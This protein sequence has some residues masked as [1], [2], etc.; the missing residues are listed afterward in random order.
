[1]S[2]S[3]SEPAANLETCLAVQAIAVRFPE[4]LEPKSQRVFCIRGFEL[5]YRSRAFEFH[6]AGKQALSFDQ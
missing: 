3:D 5:R 6:H 1:M 2:S 4:T